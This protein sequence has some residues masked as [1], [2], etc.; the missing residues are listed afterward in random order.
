MKACACNCHNGSENTHCDACAAGRRRPV[1]R[2]ALADK[3]IA[4]CV[5]A[6][7]GCLRWTGAHTPTGY[8]HI[9]IDWKTRPVH[10]VAHELWI[11]PVPDGYDIDH[12][13]EKGCRYR[14]CIEPSHLE[15][16]T[17]ATNVLRAY[18]ARRARK[19]EESN[20]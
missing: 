7:T 2:Q 10:K 12:V 11:G 19:A 1:A 18:A 8:G 20:A 13:Y 17:H 9:R 6:E 5:R 15:A 16:V 3:L 14:D 4:R